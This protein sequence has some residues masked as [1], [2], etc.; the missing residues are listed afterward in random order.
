MAETP[1]LEALRDFGENYAA[2]RE[3]EGRRLSLE[4]LR[5]LPHLRAGP[6]AWA[7]SIKA[8]TF[9]AFT[10]RVVHPMRA[11]LG[12]SLTVLDLGAGN[13]WLSYR[14]ALGGDHCTAVDIRDDDVDGLGA[15]QALAEEAGFER[16]QATFDDLP[17]KDNSV[18]ICAFNAALH[19]S[20]DLAATLA[21]AAR[22]VRS[23]GVI[24]ILDSP[25][26]QRE[27]DG[28][29]MVA[30]KHLSAPQYFGERAE[31]LMAVPSIEFLTRERL[32]KASEKLG[33]NWKRHR[34]RYPFSY[35]KRLWKAVLG[36]KRRPSRF[37][38]WVATKP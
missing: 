33:L 5:A 19:Y 10:R 16:K 38:L 29:A 35:E 6:Q 3:A 34:V 22:C 11:A 13:C 21:E 9:D 18:D 27:E 25:F 31:A 36:G 4:E 14:L 7:W 17:L 26:Y 20:T 12:R 1:T 24:A 32:G 23:G 30:E 2:Q 37:D 15:G 8:R 28:A